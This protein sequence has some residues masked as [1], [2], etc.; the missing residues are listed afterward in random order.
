MVLEELEDPSMLSASVEDLLSYSVLE[1]AAVN[2]RGGNGLV[3]VTHRVI[4]VIIV[5]NGYGFL[6]LWPVSA[7]K[8]KFALV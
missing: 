3:P 1:G 4:V 8:Q 2:E 5:A 7:S 6:I